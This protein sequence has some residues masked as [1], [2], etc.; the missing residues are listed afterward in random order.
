MS[1]DVATHHLSPALSVWHRYDSIVKADLFSTRLVTASGI[2]L[3]DP[4]PMEPVALQGLLGGN[5]L[6]GIVV[7]N[8]NHAR[9]SLALSKRLIVNIYAH[10]EARADLEG[11]QV[12][13]LHDG[14]RIA[15]DFTAT[16]IS[17][18]APGEVALHCEADGGTLILGDALINM[19]PDAFTFLP[20]KYCTNP[21]LM[22]RSLRKLLDYRFER[23]LF[24]HGTP[25][26]SQAQ[27]RLAR[28]LS[29]Q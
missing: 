5:S 3:I 10:A 6:A 16:I 4:I 18:A 21:K 24:A 9:A 28:L 29:G 27:L 20:P 22:R 25:I 15:P 8:G 12:I 14:Y 13:E 2:Y 23:I 7:T 26:V 1:F 19:A 17:G 11:S